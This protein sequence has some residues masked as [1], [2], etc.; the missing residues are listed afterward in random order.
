MINSKGTAERNVLLDIL[1]ERK[2]SCDPE[3]QDRPGQY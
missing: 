1:R 3:V 2:K